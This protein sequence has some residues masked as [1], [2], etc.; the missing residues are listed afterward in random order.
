MK[1]QPFD[2][3]KHLYRNEAFAELVKDAVRFFNG[4]PV[5]PIPPAES[6][7]GTGVYALYY[8]GK[9]PLYTKYAELNRLAYSYPIYVGKAVPKGWRQA[10]TSDNLLNQSR[11]LAGR[12]R[13]HGRSISVGAELALEDFMCRFVIFEADGSDMIGTIEAALIRLNTPL[14]NTVVDGFGNHDPGS[15]RYGKAKS[16][17]DVIHEGRA[18]ANKCN[19]VPTEKNVIVANILRHLQNTG[20]SL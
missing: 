16:D 14:W 12:L 17:W 3:S 4:T 6:F 7:L 19:G 11:E 13:E 9:N 5:H 18:W 10:R 8:T 2:R 15:G 20:F 1:L